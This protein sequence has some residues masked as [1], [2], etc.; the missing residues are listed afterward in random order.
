MSKPEPGVQ[1]EIAGKK[2]PPLM[3]AA[4][5]V[6]AS[7]D[8]SRVFFVTDTEMTQEAAQLKLHDPELYECEI[9]ETEAGEPACKLTRVSAGESTGPA[10]VHMVLA[11]SPDGSVVYFTAD[12]VLAGNEN[13]QGT[14]AVAGTCHNGS[15]AD[16]S[17]GIDGACALYRYESGG[18]PAGMTY[19]AMT[20]AGSFG[21]GT[22]GGPITPEP[23]FTGVYAT[24]DAASGEGAYL[25]FP[26]VECGLCR[27]HYEAAS[28][29]GGSLIEVAANGAF[30][31]SAVSNVSS[32]P[33]RA[34]SENGEYVFFDSAEA[35]VP[36][37]TGGSLDTYE[38]H[39]GVISLLGSGSDRS[40]TFFL[41]YSPYSLPD[42]TKVE[43]GDVFIG[44]HA[45]L[46]VQDTNSEGNIYDVRICEPESPCITPAAGE[47]AVCLGGSCQ[48]PAPAPSD[49]PSTLLAPPA[50]VTSA[51]VATKVKQTVKCKKGLVKA[52]IKKKA[53]CSK[54]HKK[55]SKAK[56]SIHQ[57]G[58]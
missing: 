1:E 45:Q 15:V 12:G 4:R 20:A 54:K 42:K 55:K 58:R 25:L 24:G 36:Q 44:T 11:V 38:W 17:G 53:T 47:T 18:A 7:T 48:T 13:S 43:G 56:K 9:T 39:D 8:G 14:H 40:P 34:M 32:G 30:T 21:N 51:P 16:G 28:P 37:A 50:P 5:Y 35:L 57:N 27:Y 19:V 26:G 10:E 23:Y 33:V 52:K 49:P 22:E 3:H 6:G 2:H 41:G 31:R 29:S 46:S